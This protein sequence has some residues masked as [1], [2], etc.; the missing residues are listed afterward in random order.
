MSINKEKLAAFQ[1]IKQKLLGMLNAAQESV[2]DSQSEANSHIGAMQSR[3]DTFKE[4]AQYLATAQKI[5][6]IKLE[7][8][9]KECERLMERLSN[10]TLT[11]RKIEP[12]AL[13]VIGDE[14]TPSLEKYFLIVPDC[15]GEW[16]SIGGRQVLSV[17]PDA[18]VIKPFIG[19]EEGEYPEDFDGEGALGSAYV[20][21]V[22]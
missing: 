18:P 13:A 8:S 10:D 3:Y 17:T 9:I 6:A 19:L 21:G 16:V 12:G 11:Y 1:G 7:G 14:G 20:K 2:R 5:R 22:C 15:A 4:E